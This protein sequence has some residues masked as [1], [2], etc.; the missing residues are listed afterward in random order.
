MVNDTLKPQRMD[1][2]LVTDS[3]V[4]YELQIIKSPDDITTWLR[5]YWHKETELDQLFVLRRA[6]YRL[7]RS[8]KLW[9]MYLD[10][11]VDVCKRL[12]SVEHK[13]EYIKVN[14]EFEKALELLQKMPLLWVKY[15]EFLLLQPDVTLIRRKFNEALRTLPLT[16]HHWI[17]PLF[18]QF[19]DEVGGVTGALIYKR[20]L[21]FAPEK[22]EDVLEKLV[23]FNDIDGSLELFTKII[24]DESFVSQH[25]KS[26]LDLWLECLELLS[27]VKNPTHKHDTRVETFIRDG[28]QKFPDQQGKLYVRLATYFLKHKDYTRAI[29]IFDEGIHT[30]LTIRDFTMIYDAYTELLESLVTRS[31]TTIEMLESAGRDTS[32]ETSLLDF[33]LGKFERLMDDRPFLLD[34]VKIRQSPNV[35]ENWIHKASLYQDL[36]MILQTYVQAITKI[37]PRQATSVYEDNGDL[38]TARTILDKA[39]NVSYNDVDELVHVWIHWSEL[40]LR[41]DDLEMAIKLWSFYLDLVESSGDVQKT[42]EVYDTV[43]ELK[44]ATPLTVVNYA[45]FLEDNNRFEDAFKRHLKLERMRDL[46]D[47]ALIGCPPDMAKTIYILYSKL[48]EDSGSVQRCVKL[49]EQVFEILL[50]KTLTHF[51]AP[52]TRS[53]Y[54]RALETLPPTK[55]INFVLKFAQTEK[56]LHEYSRVRAILQHGAMLQSPSKSQQ[57]WDWWSQFEVENGDKDTYKDMLRWKRKAN[58][59][60]STEFNTESL[61]FIKSTDGPKVSSINASEEQPVENPDAIDLDI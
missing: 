21:T 9:V 29:T 31:M 50:Q 23:E 42:C 20:Y 32:Q 61:G 17:W 33:R 28:L 22:L 19:A 34:D 40:E 8:Y 11:R 5:Y 18:I 12:N 60:F 52:S 54:T 27:N 15:L 56:Q 57:L 4:Q 59:E 55:S 36:S 25:G 13:Q 30:V 26:P 48:E 43:F 39:V 10:L 51:G 58:D 35:V 46:F 6:C 3:D 47:H 45:N 2:S 14:D 38:D 16:Q 44:I 7:K 24:N 53:I 49:L 37:D 41:Q 1:C